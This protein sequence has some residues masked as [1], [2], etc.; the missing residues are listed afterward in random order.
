MQ[1]ISHS[2]PTSPAS[3]TP[4]PS[5]NPGSLANESVF[6]QLLVAQLENQDPENPASGTEFVTQLAQFTTLQEDMQSAHDLDQIVAGVNALAKA[7][8]A[9]PG[10]A[11]AAG[12]PSGSGA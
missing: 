7:L 2:L 12:I 9:T 5:A 4:Q 3:A 11:T 10:A 8:P 6:L 1:P